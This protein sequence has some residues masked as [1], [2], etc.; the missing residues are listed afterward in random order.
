MKQIFISTSRSKCTLLNFQLFKKA[1]SK[2]N[3]LCK[4]DSQRCG[5]VDSSR[6]RNVENEGTQ[7]FVLVTKRL[8]LPTLN[9][10]TQ[11]EELKEVFMPNFTGREINRNSD[12]T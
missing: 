6:G 1:F 2:N 10:P 9:A 12:E 11:L 3:T 7:I 4:N 5:L 8:Q